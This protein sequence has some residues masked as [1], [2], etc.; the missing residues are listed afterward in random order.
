MSTSGNDT[1]TITLL[2]TKLNIPRVTSDLID[3]PHLLERLNR[4]LDRNLTLISASA[5]YGKT[6]LAAAW[7][8]DSSHPVAWLSLDEDDSDLIVF[9]NYV[10]AAIRTIFPG[11]CSQTQS[12]RQ[13]PQ[14]PPVEYIAD[15]FIN[16]ISDLSKDDLYR[17]KGYWT[18]GQIHLWRLF[19]SLIRL[20]THNLQVKLAT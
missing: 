12:L 4:G 5:G 1:K 13:A 10:V 17:F 20:Y 11:A 18:Q 16:D 14:V 7:L 9:L 15:T 19:A 3:R 8:Q 6:M 2:Q